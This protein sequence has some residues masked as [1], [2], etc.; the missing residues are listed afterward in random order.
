MSKVEKAIPLEGVTALEVRLRCGDLTIETEEREDILLRAESARE[1]I[2]LERDLEIERVGE[3]LVIR[4]A[5]T[6]RFNLRWG[7]EMDIRL[8]LP[9]GRPWK[10]NGELGQGDVAVSDLEGELGIKT[11][12]GDVGVTSFQGELTINLGQG[13]VALNRISGP[14]KTTVGQGDIRLEGWQGGEEEICA[15]KSSAGDVEVDEVTG[16]SIKVKSAMGDCHLRRV[17]VS[18]LR[19]ETAKGDV[20]CDG[21]PHDGRWELKTALGNITLSLPADVSARVSATTSFGEI[22]SDFPLVQ[23]GR[24]GPMGFLGGRMVGNMGEGE[25]RA[26]IELATAKG[27]IKLQARTPSAEGAPLP[28]GSKADSAN[29]ARLRVLESLSRGEL[30]VEEAEELLRGLGI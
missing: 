16:P 22:R 23:V 28:E 17:R 15:L 26:E 19:A 21:D 11:G 14:V 25:P 30:S 10:V 4:Q 9:A 3:R 24:Q 8:H 12:Q 1:E 20:S 7:E 29:A 18:H 13:D 6:Y 2:R 27:D 5:N